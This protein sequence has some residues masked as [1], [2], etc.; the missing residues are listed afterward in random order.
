LSIAQTRQQRRGSVPTAYQVVDQFVQAV[1][2]SAAWLRVT[3]SCAKGTVEINGVS[4]GTFEVCSKAPDRS[5]VIFKLSNV[6]EYKSGFDGQKG[7]HQNPNADAEY[8]LESKQAALKRDADSYKYVHFRQHFPKAVVVGTANVN[9]EDAY[10]V[11]ATPA[12]ESIP[13]KLYFGM[14]SK[15]LLRRDVSHGAGAGDSSSVTIYSDYRQVG[16]VKVA[17]AVRNIG[18][19]KNIFVYKMTEEKNNVAVDDALFTLP[20]K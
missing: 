4:V 1:G 11:E 6:G 20:A 12:G 8:E 5:L 18:G 15:L 13:E 3:S 14:K 17:F 16:E 2:G 19:G 7:W 10:V 9:G